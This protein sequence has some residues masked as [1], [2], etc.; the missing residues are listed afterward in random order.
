[1]AGIVLSNIDDLAAMVTDGAKVAVPPD[2][3]GVAM[4]LT[5][6]LVRRG[7]RGLHLVCVPVTGLQGDMLIGAGAV[8]TIET[9]AVT[10]GEFGGAPRF[11]NALKSGALKIMDAT[12][13]AVHAG[14]QA[15]Q[16]GIPYMPLRGMIGSDIL[17]NRSDWKVQ[18]NP[19]SDEEDPIVLLPAI[20]PDF[21]IFHGLKADRQGN[22]Y[23]GIRREL[24]A[25]AG[26]AKQSLVT[27]EEIVDGNLLEDDATAAGTLPG[28]YVGGVVEAKRGCWPI[29]FWNEYGT[30]GAHMQGYV[31]AARSDEGFAAYVQEFVHGAASAE[32]AE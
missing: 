2:Y 11:Q 9:S 10:L 3:S 29:S 27:V 26:A 31:A 22:V 4:E 14:I 30:D 16:K 17:K 24:F 20:R 19:F 21:A 23:L 8:D 12:C 5:R 6:A 15:G 13:P 28:L 7:V 1:M 18:Q 32:A 25:M